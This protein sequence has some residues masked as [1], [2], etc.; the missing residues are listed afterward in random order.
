MALA[1][2]LALAG[3]ARGSELILFDGSTVP[4][5]VYDARDGAPI[6]HAAELL[7][8]D[9]RSLTG[10]QPPVVPSVAQGRG[11]AVIVGRADSPAIAALLAANGI[12]AAPIRG[13]WETYGRAVIPAPWNAGEKALLIFGSDTRG[14]IWGVVDLT[15]EM[16]VSPW[17]WWADVTPA[18]PGGSMF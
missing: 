17:E 15:R 3:F 6:A 7:A 14:A 11:A 9:L 13:K 8:G 16:G 10:I 5:V 18:K 12:D 1:L 4:A 2:T